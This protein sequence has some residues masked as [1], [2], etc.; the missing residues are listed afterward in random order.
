MPMTSQENCLTRSCSPSRL[1]HGAAEELAA[2]GFADHADGRAGALFV[3]V[4]KF[5]ALA[6]FQ[7]P[8]MSQSLVLPVTLVVQLRPLATTVAP[9]RASG[10]TAATPPIWLAMAS[11]SASLKARAAAAARPHA[12]AGRTMQQVGAQAGDLVLHRQR[13]AVA[14]GD[15][16]DHGADADH[17]AQDGQERAQQVAP[18]RAQASST[19]C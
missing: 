7:L 8:V 19:G 5:A 11:A 13:G 10:A 6:S 17:D 15:H 2:H 16:G 4:G 18:D 1:A 12:L 9:V 14:Q 3:S